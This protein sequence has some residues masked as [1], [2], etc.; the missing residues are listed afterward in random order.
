MVHPATAPCVPDRDSHISFD[1]AGGDP[2][3]TR[4]MVSET[5]SEQLESL[6]LS[7]CESSLIT[8]ISARLSSVTARV[9]PSRLQLA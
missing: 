9:R 7:D 3:A 5:T 6:T 4:L 1:H 2:G 8:I